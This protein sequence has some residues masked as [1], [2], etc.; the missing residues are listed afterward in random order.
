[1][2]EIIIGS[3][4][5]G[6]RVDRFLCKY[7]S[8]STRTN[9]FKLIRKKLIKVNGKKVKEN[10]FLVEG[11][12]LKI[13]LQ[14]STLHE[15]TGNIEENISNDN[16]KVNL[17]I[18]YEDDNMLIVDKPRGQLTHPDKKDDKESLSTVVNQYLKDKITLT[19]KPASINRLDRNTSGLVVFCKDYDTL[20]LLNEKSR[21]REIKKYYQT[22]V[23]GKLSGSG[24]VKGYLNKDKDKNIVRLKQE[25]TSKDDLYVHTKYKSTEIKGGT[26]LVDVELLTGRSHQ[27]RVSLSSIGHPIMGDVKYKS[28]KN[29]GVNVRGQLLHAYKI[30]IDDKCYE[31]NSKEIM[32]I[33]NKL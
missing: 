24:E 25:K 5:A 1:M 20:K 21:N 29:L 4:E 16:I 13:F 6:Q 11:D 12:S 32:D 3:N 26:S 15:L 22:I 27:I 17:D 19:F 14:D 33:W 23:E 10:Y 7:M 18:V 2:K 31:K 30:C 28:V 9:V 8:K